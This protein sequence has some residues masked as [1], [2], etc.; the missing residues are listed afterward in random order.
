M[1]EGDMA[2][3]HVPKQ[4]LAVLGLVGR[5]DLQGLFQPYGSKSSPSSRLARGR[6]LSSVL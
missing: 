5:D 6:H 4:W 1:P 3:N 2:L